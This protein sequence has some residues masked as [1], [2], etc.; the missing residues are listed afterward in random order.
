MEH[1]GYELE[2]LSHK[3]RISKSEEILEHTKCIECVNGYFHYR[4]P[5]NSKLSN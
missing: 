1:H 3:I 4:I 5:G 2:I